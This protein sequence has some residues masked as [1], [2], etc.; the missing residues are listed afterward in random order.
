MAALGEASDLGLTQAV[1]KVERGAS[2]AQMCKT[3]YSRLSSNQCSSR[4]APASD[5]SRLRCQEEGLAGCAPSSWTTR[6]PVQCRA[7]RL[8]STRLD[9]SLFSSCSGQW[10]AC[11]LSQVNIQQEPDK[12]ERPNLAKGYVGSAPIA[13]SYDCSWKATYGG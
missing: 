6:R 8:D 1:V 2:K 3:L 13:A 5:V 7:G 10:R 9:C 11:C 4:P 12:R